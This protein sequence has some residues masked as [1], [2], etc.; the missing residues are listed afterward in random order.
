MDRIYMNRIDGQRR[1]HIE[2]TDSEVSDLLEDLQP[3]P[4]HYDSTNA[5]LAL[6]DAAEETFS[7]VVAEGR[8]DRA[9]RTASGPARTTGHQP[10]IRCGRLLA[11]QTPGTW[12]DCDQTDGHDGPHTAA[13]TAGGQ[14]PKP[15]ACAC[16]HPQD[17]HLSACTECPC[18][19]YAPT[20]PRQTTGS[21][22]PDSCSACPTFPCRKCAPAVGQP[23][24]A[25]SADEALTAAERQ[26]LTFALELAADEMASRPGFTDEDDAAL[27]KLLRMTEEGR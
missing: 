8:R 7:P 14:Q 17:R 19:G 4:E 24:E 21:E 16:T 20:W 11:G 1:I 18:V 13:R 23:A 10:G 2:I 9:A 5:F 22:G 27:T 26:F 15:A 3:D 12:T 6:L 25:Q